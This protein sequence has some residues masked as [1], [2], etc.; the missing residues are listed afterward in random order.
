MPC[1]LLRPR[2]TRR[3]ARRDQAKLDDVLSAL[4]H[5]E[6]QASLAVDWGLRAVLDGPLGP[7]LGLSRLPEVET[8]LRRVSAAL[9]DAQAKDAA[10][11]ASV[12]QDLTP[13]L[14]DPYRDD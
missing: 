13:L 2:S 7:T 14:T 11:Q 9:Q 12:E 3:A 6:A 4:D 1:S 10:A 8:G 5:A